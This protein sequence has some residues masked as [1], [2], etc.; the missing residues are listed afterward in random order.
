MRVRR[1]RSV[2]MPRTSSGRGR[3]RILHD[4]SALGPPF[5]FGNP[6]ISVKRSHAGF[7]DGHLLLTE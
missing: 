5:R 6:L 7:Q 1:S 2:G 4:H 3:V